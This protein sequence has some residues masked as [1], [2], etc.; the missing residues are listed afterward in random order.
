MNERKTFRNFLKLFY[1]LSEKIINVWIFNYMS[2]YFEGLSAIQENYNYVNYKNNFYS[3]SI[4]IQIISYSQLFNSKK[5]QK[6]YFSLLSNHN[7]NKIREHK[8]L[9]YS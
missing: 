1:F 3:H 9:S 8:E 6:F 7:D 4:F 5:F 2:L